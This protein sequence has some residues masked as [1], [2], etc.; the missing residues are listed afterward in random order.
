M[1]FNNLRMWSRHIH[2]VIFNAEALRIDE[3]KYWIY[4]QNNYSRFGSGE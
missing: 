3:Y 4:S 2:R 1:N